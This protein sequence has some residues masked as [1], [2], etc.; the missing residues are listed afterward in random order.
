MFSK[1]LIS[2]LFISFTTADY[3]KIISGMN[4]LAEIAKNKSIEQG[5]PITD[6]DFSGELIAPSLEEINHYGCWC[7]FGEDEYLQSKGPVQD[8][9]DEA[10]KI[11]NNGYKCATIDGL[12]RGTACD[13]SKIDYIKYDYFSGGELHEECTTLNFDNQEDAACAID[14]CIIEGNFL[15]TMFAY[16]FGFPSRFPDPT[17]K[18]ENVGG[19]FNV[20][21]ECKVGGYNIQSERECCGQVPNRYPFKIFNGERSCCGEKTF[22][23]INLKCCYGD[24][25][26]PQL[27]NFN[28]EC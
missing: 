15:Q 14:A 1:L 4:Q 17:F 22:N 26:N 7:Y 13:A 11:L 9:F 16:F 5:I 12:E 3:Q 10:C 6:R 8:E 23:S 18:H 2:T 20:E 25:G 24:T 27:K 28:E 21:D 19:V